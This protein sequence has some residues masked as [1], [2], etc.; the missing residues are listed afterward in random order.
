[1]AFTRPYLEGLDRAQLRTLVQ[2]A[3]LG[4]SWAAGAAKADLVDTLLAGV[5]TFRGVEG[6]PT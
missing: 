6:V 1:M 4:G 5:R 2:E 3:S